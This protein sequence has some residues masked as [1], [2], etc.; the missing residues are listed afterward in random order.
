MHLT[1]KIRI[2]PMHTQERVLWDLSEKCRLLYNYSLA[3]RKVDWTKN[4][5]LPKEKR[6]Y[7]TYYEQ[8]KRLPLIKQK[9]PEYKWT[10]SKVLQHTLKKLDFAFKSYFS[11]R[12]RGDKTARP[13][14]FRGKR[15]FFT[16]CFLQ[17]GFKIARNSI[18]FSHKHPLN[19][20]L[21]FKLTYPYKGTEKVKQ[22]EISKD[23]KE[24]WY[25]SITYDLEEP[26]YVDNGLYYAID[27]GISNLVSGVNLDRKAIQIRNKRPDLYWRKKIAEVQSKR[28]HCKGSKTAPKKSRRWIKYHHKLCSMK[29]KCA[30]QMRDF[31]HFVAKTIIT[32]TKANTI[33]IGDLPVKKMAKR[34]K[35]TGNAKKTKA[36]KTLNH[37]LQNTG[38]LGR[39][40]QFLTYKAEKLGKRVIR[41]DER[42][43]SQKCCICEH[44]RKR[45]LYE[46]TI[47]CDCGNS[48]D[49]DVNSAINIMERFIRNKHK[50]IKRYNFL[51]PES[52][53]NEESFL[54]K[55]DLLRNTA[56]SPG[57]TVMVDS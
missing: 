25:V 26:A 42:G 49:R 15:Y 9:F 14:K 23:L 51:S 41:I 29:R 27:L 30:Q 17:S 21:V 33:I 53:V 34:K 8:S 39:F 36:N 3:K 52:S 32:N 47:T 16:M 37:S 11:K 19:I 50:Y 24:K 4:Q 54:N 44:R 6:K 35:G 43:T 12:E 18:V 22:V 31:Q 2:Y 38:S 28:D 13:P 57:K 48:L 1:Q 40:A 7:I 10:Y 20:P 5:E 45:R 46:R 55:L 56:P